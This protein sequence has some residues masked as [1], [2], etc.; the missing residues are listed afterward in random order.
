[1]HTEEIFIVTFT[2]LFIT[3]VESQ[4]LCAFDPCI[5]PN[6]CNGMTCF[7][8]D[9]CQH[10][11][12]C[13]E[14]SVADDCKNITMTT[15]TSVTSTVTKKKVF[16]C[17]CENSDCLI[18]RENLSFCYCDTGWGGE[19]CDTPCL[20]NCSENER[21][22][23]VPDIPIMSYCKKFT[24]DEEDTTTSVPVITSEYS[25]NRTYNVC[26]ASYTLRPISERICNGWPCQYGTCESNGTLVW[27]NC[28]P[29]AIGTMCNR[30]CCKTC[31]YGSC[32]YD[33]ERHT[34]LCNC[35]ANYSGPFCE[36][37][38]PPSK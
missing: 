32:F 24:E 10:F 14:N 38:D 25:N 13:D 9:D 22:F 4:T 35:H 2:V 37:W 23:P 18:A 6:V 20:L 19:R 30:E 17:K 12:A 7:L 3:N 21:C 11:C 29:G 15:S 34:E 28:D 27:C 8:G 33:N 5:I 16:H 26:D 1:M 36:R 31:L